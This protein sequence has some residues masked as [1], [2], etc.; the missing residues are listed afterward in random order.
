LQRAQQH[1]VSRTGTFGLREA[2][3]AR[4][5]QRDHLGQHFALQADG[6]RAQRMHVRLPQLARG[7]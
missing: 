2:D 5:G 3:A 6:Q 4:F 1:L 7:T